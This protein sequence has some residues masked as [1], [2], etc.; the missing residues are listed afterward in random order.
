MDIADHDPRVSGTDVCD[1]G[2]GERPVGAPCFGCAVALFV[3]PA[4]CACDCALGGLC[5][6]EWTGPTRAFD[7]GE[8]ATC[9]HCGLWE[10]EH[11]LMV[12]P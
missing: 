9:A 10:I 11:D 8:T 4:G 5:S 12:M 7:R 3:C 2:H 6:H 1:A